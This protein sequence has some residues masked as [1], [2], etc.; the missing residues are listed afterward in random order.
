MVVS[1]ETSAQGRALETDAPPDTACRGEGW[2]THQPDGGEIFDP[3]VAID[4]EPPGW[5]WLEGTVRVAD[6]EV[7]LCDGLEERC[8]TYAVT[9]GIDPAGMTDGAASRRGRFIGRARDDA[10]EGLIFVPAPADLQ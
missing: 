8:R 9:R 3:S 6:D 5:I 10:I 4:Q 2:V 1:S 7:R